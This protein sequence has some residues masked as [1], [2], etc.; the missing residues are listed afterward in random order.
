M[1]LEI[2]NQ[3]FKKYLETGARSN[4]KLKIL[5]AKIALDL[6]EKFGANYEIYALGV[7][8]EKELKGRYY[9]KAVDIAILKN[10][11]E[12]GGVAVKFVMSNFSQNANNY[13]ENMLGETANLRT[14]NLPYFQILIVSEA[15]PYFKKDETISKIEELT[16]H[17]LSKYLKLSQDNAEVFFHTPNKTLLVIVKLPDTFK[18]AHNKAEFKAI[19]EKAKFS[20][21]HKFDELNFNQ[22]VILNDYELFLEKI[23]H[24]ILAS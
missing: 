15:M 19:C 4:E 14:N 3:S 1:F 21:S 17:H 10:E 8:K 2:L 22:G 13:F 6:K 7:N 5:H 16:N 20:Y 11:C 18:N 12:V 9:D 24:G 23:Y